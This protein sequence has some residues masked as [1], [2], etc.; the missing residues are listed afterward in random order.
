MLLN[1]DTI[2]ISLIMRHVDTYLRV[3]VF[4]TGSGQASTKRQDSISGVA[5]QG[6]FQREPFRALCHTSGLFFLLLSHILS[7]I[8]YGEMVLSL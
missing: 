2:C 4:A 3:V 1:N 8:L 5:H 6:I 7:S